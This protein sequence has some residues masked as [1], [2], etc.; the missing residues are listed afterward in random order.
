MESG[1]SFGKHGDWKRRMQE[2]GGKEKLVMLLIGGK[3]GV[4]VDNCVVKFKICGAHVY[5]HTH[6]HTHAQPNARPIPS[7][8]YPPLT[9]T[10]NAA[11]VLVMVR[12]R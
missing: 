3:G 1:P 2:R 11:W 4:R 10:G 12:S 6:T 9:S 7:P 5:T 8:P